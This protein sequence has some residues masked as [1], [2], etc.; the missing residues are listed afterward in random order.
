MPYITTFPA[1]A[2]GLCTMACMPRMAD[3]GG[4]MMGIDSREPNTPPLLTVN[5]PPCMSA[6]ERLP[7]GYGLSLGRQ[8]SRDRYLTHTPA[9]NRIVFYYIV[10]IG[11]TLTLWRSI[12]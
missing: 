2:T 11:K 5:V 8:F 6:T 10:A 9:D 12:A 3:C 1:M 7:A 4:L